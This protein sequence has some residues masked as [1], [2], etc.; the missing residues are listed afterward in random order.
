MAPSSSPFDEDMIYVLREIIQID[1]TITP[2]HEIPK[3]LIAESVVKWNNFIAEGAAKWYDFKNLSMS[4]PIRNNNRNN[5]S[6]VSVAKLQFFLKYIEKRSHDSTDTDHTDAKS[7][8]QDEFKVY[9]KESWKLRRDSSAA[10]RATALAIA[11]ATGTTVPVGPSYNTYNAP[12]R[13]LALPQEGHLESVFRIYTY[14]KG[15]RNTLMI[16]DPGEPNI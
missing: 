5:L 8:K 9:Y 3:A 1:P 10:A 15:K 16:F 12:Q 7:Y 6:N 11:A 13:V 4:Y 2:L 14:L